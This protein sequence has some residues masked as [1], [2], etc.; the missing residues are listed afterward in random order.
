MDQQRMQHLIEQHVQAE[1]AGDV[2]TAISMYTDDIEHDV[3]G[4]PSGPTRGPEGAAGF[5]HQLMSDLV[6]EQMDVKRAQYGPDFCVVEHEA[7][8]VVQGAF[9][10]VPGNG[11]RV[12][13]R[14]LHVW[15]FKDDRIGREQIWIDGGS[16]VAQLTA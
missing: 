2:Q 10:G 9:A 5:Y 6:T 1:I 11:R 4:F 3:I 12:T 16:I 14:M 8:C 13:F 15:D 7:T